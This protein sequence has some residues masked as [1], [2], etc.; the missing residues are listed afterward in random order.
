VTLVEGRSLRYYYEDGI[1][2]EALGSERY[3]AASVGDIFANATTS[4][5]PAIRQEKPAGSLLW[6]PVMAG[7]G[8]AAL[9]IA[10]WLQRRNLRTE[11]P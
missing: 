4:D 3:D 11:Q 1:L 9:A 2:K 10:L 5:P 6:W 7:G 8:L